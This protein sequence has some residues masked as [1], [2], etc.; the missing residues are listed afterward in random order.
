M[1]NLQSPPHH[2]TRLGL[3]QTYLPAAQQQRPESSRRFSKRKAWSSAPSHEIICF[4]TEIS[5]S[6]VTANVMIP[7]RRAD[8]APHQPGCSPL[9][10]Y[11]AA[12]LGSARKSIS[13]F[14]AIG[15]FDTYGAP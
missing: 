1:G 2:S 8:R 4:Q 14:A 9:A 12:A 6:A 15:C 10:L 11:A 7:L 3:H 13:A 5:G